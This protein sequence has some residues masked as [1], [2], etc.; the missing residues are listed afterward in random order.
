[1]SPVYY[2]VVSLGRTLLQPCFKP[3]LSL[4]VW[5]AV[6]ITVFANFL[7][8]LFDAVPSFFKIFGTLS[9]M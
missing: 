1:M 2:A 4:V 9:L 5:S 8:R 6:L 3:D 7:F